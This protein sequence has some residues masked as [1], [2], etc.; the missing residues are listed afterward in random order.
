MSSS[1]LSFSLARMVLNPSPPH[2]DRAALLLQSLLF[3]ILPV[4]VGSAQTSPHSTTCGKYEVERPLIQSSF[5]PF[6]LEEREG[7][8]QGVGLVTCRLSGIGYCWEYLHN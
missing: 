7:T 6:T 2:L 5:A 8:R 3:F 4:S 1:L